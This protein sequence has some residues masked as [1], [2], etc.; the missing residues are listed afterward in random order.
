MSRKIG[1]WQWVAT[2]RSEA[3]WAEEYSQSPSISRHNPTHPKDFTPSYEADSQRVYDAKVAICASEVNKP[4]KDRHYA[5]VPGYPAEPCKRTDHVMIKGGRKASRYPDARWAGGKAPGV[6]PPDPHESPTKRTRGGGPKAESRGRPR[7]GSLPATEPGKKKGRRQSRKTGQRLGGPNPLYYAR[8]QPVVS[9]TPSKPGLVVSGPGL[10]ITRAIDRYRQKQPRG[11]L[12]FAVPRSEWPLIQA[13][14]PKKA[15]RI[16]VARAGG[17]FYPDV[18][19]TRMVATPLLSSVQEVL[20]PL[21]VFYDEDADGV[22]V[23]IVQVRSRTRTEAGYIAELSVRE[24]GVPAEKAR[25]SILVEWDGIQQAYQRWVESVKASRPARTAGWRAGRHSGST[26]GYNAAEDDPLFLRDF[27]NEV[28]TREVVKQAEAWKSPQVVIETIFDPSGME[29]DAPFS[30][31]EHSKLGQY[32]ALPSEVDYRSL[33]N[34]SLSDLPRL[35]VRLSS[36]KKRK[37]RKL[38]PLSTARN[39]PRMAKH[40]DNSILHI[41]FEKAYAPEPEL[42]PVP[43]KPGRV[44]W[45]KTKQKIVSERVVQK[46]EPIYLDGSWVTPDSGMIGRKYRVPLGLKDVDSSQA[47]SWLTIAETG[48]KLQPQL[49]ATADKFYAEEAMPSRP[50]LPGP[51]SSTAAIPARENPMSKRDYWMRQYQKG[52]YGASRSI[53]AARR[54][55]GKRKLSPES[56]AKFQ[57][58]GRRA[59]QIA[60]ASGCDMSSAMRQAWAEVKGMQAAA[61]PWYPGTPSLYLP[62]NPVPGALVRA[63]YE[64]SDETEVFSALVPGPYTKKNPGNPQ[65]KAAMELYHSGQA[66][67]LKEAWAMVKGRR[68]PRGGR[69]LGGHA[70]RSGRSAHASDPWHSQYEQSIGQFS[71]QEQYTRGFQPMNRRNPGAMKARFPGQCCMCGVDFNRGED[72]AD[73]GMRGP[74][75]GKKMAHIGCL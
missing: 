68:N 41:V 54:N 52:P 53:P 71:T 70:A 39:N 25:A 1:Y 35:L 74:R 3:P 43:E 50:L 20:G 14:M 24:G 23:P 22:K 45:P 21:E 17:R 15:A 51:T 27:F 73:S 67:S 61:N 7:R 18:P 16:L 64:W 38:K 48:R 66:S 36:R 5:Y 19:Y 13:G 4:W 37:G 40:S 2:L 10:D 31:G 44:Y 60:K 34:V 28:L 12:G 8:T 6:Y 63:P 69:K 57:A 59:Q 72:I 65:A 26:G 47:E 42:I 33:Q 49:S 9:G 55:K 75:G 11:E 58:V 32:E 56:R 29:F 30:A 46:G 62:D